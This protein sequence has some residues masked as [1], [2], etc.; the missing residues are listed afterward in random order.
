MTAEKPDLG[1]WAWISNLSCPGS[2]TLLGVFVCF[3]LLFFFFQKLLQEKKPISSSL[4]GTMGT[5]PL[6][7]TMRGEA[8]SQVTGEDE[9]N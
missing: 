8:G 4:E 6:P 3:F 5:V 7:S 2:F 1:A 9:G